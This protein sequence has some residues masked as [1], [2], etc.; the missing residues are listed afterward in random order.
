MAT[1]LSQ[2]KPI[3]VRFKNESD[4]L[5][6]FEVLL[7]SGMPVHATADD[8]YIINEV[9]CNLLTKKGIEYVKEQ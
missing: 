8:R 1:D 9:L 5:K 6:G 7:N 2:L 3:K 4:E